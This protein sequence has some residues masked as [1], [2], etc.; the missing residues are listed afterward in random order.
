VSGKYVLLNG[1]VVA[2]L[3]N[4]IPEGRQVI[5]AQFGVYELHADAFAYRFDNVSTFTQTVNNI[6]VSHTPPWEGMRY[7]EVRQEGATLRFQSRSLDQAEFIFN[8]DVLRY[9][10]GGKLLRV[11]R[12]TKSE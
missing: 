9:S 2:V 1:T 12:R 10:V 4:R 7:F 5:T 3:I 11:W 8:T 6:A